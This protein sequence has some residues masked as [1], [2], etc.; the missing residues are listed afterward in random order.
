MRFHNDEPVERNK[1]AEFVNELFS[2]LAYQDSADTDIHSSFKW[3]YDFL[4]RYKTHILEKIA[5]DAERMKHDGKAWL[6]MM[7]E[8]RRAGFSKMKSPEDFMDGRNQAIED[9][10]SILKQD[11]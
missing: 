5:E 7:H 2:K 9:V 8:A 6:T 3:A 10:L 11:V 4:G 1:D